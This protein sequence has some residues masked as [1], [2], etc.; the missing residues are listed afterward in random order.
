MGKP[1]TSEKDIAEII[2][3]RKSGLSLDSI[4]KIVP[5]GKTTIFTY[6]KNVK[7]NFDLRGTGS[8]NKSDNE[9]KATKIAAVNLLGDF[10]KQSKLLVLAAL[11][12][13]EGNKK[14]LNLINSDPELIRVFVNCLKELGVRSE[15]LKISLR[16]FE[17]LNHKKAKAFWSG[18][19][20]V[21]KNLIAGIEIIKGKEKG[22][23]K[24]GMCRV[25]VRKSH[26]YFK[27]IMNM[28]DLMK[29]GL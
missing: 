12:W 5:Q 3:L 18:I 21:S 1:K 20:G 28:I 16:L 2:R 9:W 10:S 23:L 29:S 6:I 7:V 19:T 13:G 14:E 25:R 22:R 4:H 15:D 11:Y 8:R 24:Y 17:D 27:L 26:Y